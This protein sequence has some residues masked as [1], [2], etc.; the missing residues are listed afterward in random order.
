MV[1]YQG[2]PYQ[3]A[4]SL[5]RTLHGWCVV[6]MALYIKALRTFGGLSTDKFQLCF[7]NVGGGVCVSR[8]SAC[9]AVDWVVF[10]S[11]GD[12]FVAKIGGVSWRVCS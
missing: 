10:D 4:F 3:L 9:D 11:C 1:D 2:L 12:V 7:W 8:N 5:L 6:A